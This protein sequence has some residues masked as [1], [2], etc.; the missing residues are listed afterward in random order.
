MALNCEY[1]AHR[2]DTTQHVL[3]FLRNEAT[4]L[5][6]ILFAKSGF[7]IFSFCALHFYVKCTTHVLIDQRTAT[8]ISDLTSILKHISNLRQEN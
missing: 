2:F 4:Q 3:H 5:Q 6:K 1:L 7:F 8:K